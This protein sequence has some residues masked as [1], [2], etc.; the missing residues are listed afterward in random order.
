MDFLSSLCLTVSVT[1]TFNLNSEKC[2]LLCIN[3]C[4]H[5]RSKLQLLPLLQVKLLQVGIQVER[6]VPRFYF[7]V[8]AVLAVEYCGSAV[9]AG[10]LLGM[11]ILGSHPDLVNEKLWRWGQQG[12]FQQ[13]LQITDKC[14]SLSSTALSDACFY[15]L[16][17]LVPAGR[18]E[19]ESKTGQ[20]L[21]LL[22]HYPKTSHF[23]T[24]D[25]FKVDSLV[26]AFSEPPWEYSSPWLFFLY[27]NISLYPSS[28]PPLFTWHRISLLQSYSPCRVHSEWLQKCSS[29]CGLQGAVF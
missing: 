11:W 29:W 21:L 4:F 19:W 28:S 2:L 20:R 5:F 24:W 3:K 26:S 15:F 25:W 6:V 27:S 7:A 9:L 22:W 14:W 23:R 17:T 1:Q 8:P 12:V 16:V 13:V 10:K 18:R